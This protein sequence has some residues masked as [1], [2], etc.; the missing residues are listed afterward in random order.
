MEGM[1]RASL[2][3]HI[4]LL[5]LFVFRPAAVRALEDGSDETCSET[6]MCKRQCGI[7][8]AMS[9]LPGTGIGMFAGRDFVA[10]ERL[11]M[12]GDLVIPTIDRSDAWLWDSYTW[13]RSFRTENEFSYHLKPH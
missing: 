12:A 13:V 10:T 6:P 5:L 2:C 9:T 3:R 8:L 1:S 7:Y 11:M 4:Q